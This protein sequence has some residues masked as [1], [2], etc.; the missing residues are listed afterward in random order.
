ML[1]L[2]TVGQKAKILLQQPGD[3]AVYPILTADALDHS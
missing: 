3:Y 2:F 1:G